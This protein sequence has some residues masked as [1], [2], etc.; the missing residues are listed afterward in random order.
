MTV[1]YQGTPLKV[2][3]TDIEGTT[4]D[5]AFVHQILFP[6]SAKYLPDWGIRSR[7]GKCYQEN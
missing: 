5:I 1:T 3:L 7:D 6:Y 4:T 2:I